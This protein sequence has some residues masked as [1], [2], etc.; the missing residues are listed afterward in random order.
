M[1]LDDPTKKM[2]KS[3]ESEYN[4]IGLTDNPEAAAKK[5]MK[6]VTDSGKEIKFDEKNKPAISNLLTIYSLLT[7][8]PIKKLEVKYGGKGPAFAEASAGKYGD[9]KKDLA[10]IVKKF[11]ADFQER[12]KK[13]SDKEVEK[14]LETGA[15][16]VRPIADE[17]LKKVKEKIGIN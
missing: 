16:K 7:D 2:S 4:Y 8:E 5:I 11:L 9:F 17:T 15:K 14:I 13:I 3:A 1:G 10:E 6:A 12:Y